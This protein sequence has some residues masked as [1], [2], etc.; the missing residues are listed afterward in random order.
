MSKIREEGYL[1][2]D[3]VSPL[4]L[5]RINELTM[6]AHASDEEATGLAA[7]AAG[8]CDVDDDCDP[9]AAA[10]AAEVDGMAA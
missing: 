8:D 7:A 4:F 10:A 9:A 3:S 5:C 2:K 6:E 1:E